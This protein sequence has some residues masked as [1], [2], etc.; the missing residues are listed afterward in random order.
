MEQKK[1]TCIGCRKKIAEHGIPFAI[2]KRCWKIL[3]NAED[4]RNHHRDLIR[5]R[6]GLEVLKFKGIEHSDTIYFVNTIA[7]QIADIEEQLQWIKNGLANIANHSEDKKIH[8]GKWQDG[9]NNKKLSFPLYPKGQS[10]HEA[11]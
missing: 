6:W 4:A 5:A 10:F 11:L 8:I 2:C 3:N 7:E 9:K 1:Y